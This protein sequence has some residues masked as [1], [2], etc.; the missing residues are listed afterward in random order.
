MEIFRPSLL[1]TLDDQC[2]RF[3]YNRWKK[4]VEKRMVGEQTVLTPFWV[5]SGQGWIISSNF[6]IFSKTTPLTWVYLTRFIIVFFYNYGIW[7]L[8]E[9]SGFWAELM[10]ATA[11]RQMQ[12]EEM[13]FI[14]F[15][16]R[17]WQISSFGIIGEWTLI[18][19]IRFLISMI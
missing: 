1:K 3:P 8:N 18:D 14:P 17:R 10:E 5:M 2:R 16:G 12:H 7:S 15:Q 4:G 19:T 13:I 6:S 11:C 9:Q